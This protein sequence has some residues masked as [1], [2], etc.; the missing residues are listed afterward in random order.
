MTTWTWGWNERKATT[1]K[2]CEEDFV[3][4]NFNGEKG[5]SPKSPYE[6]DYVMRFTRADGPVI[7]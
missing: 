6:K 2:R 4:H 1:M 7:N 5:E 3:H